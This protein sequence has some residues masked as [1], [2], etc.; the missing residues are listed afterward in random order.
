MTSAWV[1]LGPDND[2]V[3]GSALLGRLA[4]VSATDHLIRKKQQMRPSSNNW[5]RPHVCK[6]SPWRTL[7]TLLFAGGTAQWGTSKVGGF[8]SAFMTTSK[9]R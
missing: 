8:W 3:H 4:W 7:T 5:K 6:Q 9:H 2:P 1:G